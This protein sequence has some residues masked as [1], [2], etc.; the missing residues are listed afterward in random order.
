MYETVK[1]PVLTKQVLGKNKIGGLRF[2]NFAMYSTE[3]G[4]AI[5][6]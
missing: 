2:S 1:D 4:S 5:T 6:T 3:C